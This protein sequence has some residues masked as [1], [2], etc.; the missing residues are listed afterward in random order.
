VCG[1]W[2]LLVFVCLI[3]CWSVCVVGLCVGR[4]VC[5]LV[6]VLVGLCGCLCVLFG[7]ACVVH[8]YPQALLCVVGCNHQN[9]STSATPWPEAMPLLGMG[10][11]PG[12]QAVIVMCECKVCA[13]L[14]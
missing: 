14:S 11:Q 3:V 2:G 4:F 6:C 7:L 12:L 1:V 8:T 9:V 5:W 13:V 10:H